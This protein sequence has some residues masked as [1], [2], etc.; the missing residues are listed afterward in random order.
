MERGGQF[1]QAY[2]GHIAVDDEWHVIVAQCASNQAPDTDDFIPMLERVRDTVG[3][4]PEKV[5]ADAGFWSPE[6]TPGW[7]RI[8]EWT[9]T[10]RPNASDTELRRRTR[11]SHRGPRR[12]AAD[13]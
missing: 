9:R 13:A 8:K 4:L 1:T 7:R 12:R 10:S 5:T 2:N 3:Q 11:P 6:K